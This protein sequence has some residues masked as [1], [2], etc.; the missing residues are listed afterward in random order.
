MGAKFSLAHLTVLDCAPPEMIYIANMAGYDYVSLR[1]ITMGLSGENNYNL[2]EDKKLLNQ[3]KRALHKTGIKVHDIELAKID[4]KTDIKNYEPAF[5]VAEELGVKN[6]ISS[7]WT[8]NRELYL[9]KFSEL[10]EL[11]NKYGLTVNLEFVTW[12]EIKDLEQAKEVLEIVDKGNVA[13]LI[14]TLHFHRSKVKPAEIDE[15]P[16]KWLRFIHLC[17]GPADIPDWDDTEALL[18]T[19][20][21]NRLY[22]G[23]GEIDLAAI[24]EKLPENIVYSIELPKI[25]KIKEIGYAEHARRSLE[26]SKKYLEKNITKKN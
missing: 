10:C 11:A 24:I 3:T 13:I 12:A 18:K 26:Y 9:E 2:A 21:D 17:D 25:D 22:P 5:K 7:I 8:S 19:G 14:D 4:E 1:I 23:K 15:I 20:R 6:V 16:D